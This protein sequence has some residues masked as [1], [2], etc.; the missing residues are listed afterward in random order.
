MLLFSNPCGPFLYIYSYLSF[1]H[2]SGPHCPLVVQ[3]AEQCPQLC[4]QLSWVSQVLAGTSPVNMLH[5]TT[6]RRRTNLA[7]VPIY[8]TELNQPMKN[9]ARY[10]EDNMKYKSS[11]LQMACPMSNVPVHDVLFVQYDS[12]VSKKWN[13]KTTFPWEKIIFEV[14]F[15]MFF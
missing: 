15:P 12:P 2:W 6:N 8:W 3:V 11:L 13:P 9:C 10:S 1:R 7:S 4:P 14:I 5:Q